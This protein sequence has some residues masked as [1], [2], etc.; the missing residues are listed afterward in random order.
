[1]CIHYSVQDSCHFQLARAT[2]LPFRCAH[3]NAKASIAFAIYL[4]VCLPHLLWHDDIEDDVQER[5]KEKKRRR[6]RDRRKMAFAM[7]MLMGPL[8]PLKLM[9]KI[10]SRR[11]DD[12][13]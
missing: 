8:P 5:G 3:S 6:K 12:D 13:C 4:S 11:S 1:M 2:K 7:L 9:S 10:V